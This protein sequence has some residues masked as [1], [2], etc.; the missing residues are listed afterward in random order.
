VL[1]GALDDDEL[2]DLDAETRALIDDWTQGEVN[3]DY[4][5]AVTSPGVESL[6]RV[7]GLLPKRARNDSV[8]SLLAHPVLMGFLRRVLGPDFVFFAADMVLKSETGSPTI[9]L[10]R[11]VP[12]GHDVE[13]ISADV[14][15]DA[16]TPHNGCV[17]FLPG[18]HLLT[19]V[20]PVLARG[21]Q[22]PG[23]VDVPVQRG[24]VVIHDGRVLHGS[25]AIPSG[26]P[27]RRTV[28]LVFQSATDVVSA[29]MA[30]AQQ[31]RH[32]A[33]ACMKLMA[34]ASEV[35]S[36]Q[37]PTDAA[38]YAPPPEWQADVDRADVMLRPFELLAQG[39]S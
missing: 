11:D 24:D 30:T 31:R 37:R 2:D 39:A 10:H 35:R 1:R 23:L 6:F 19:D 16:A 33:A 36:R 5:T 25:P 18:S 14:Y 15:L 34:H 4:W 9:G 12:V 21:L 13:M 22:A 26:R 28:Y 27:L 7:S 29:P 38:R 8:L 3:S 20:A 17:R 32:Y